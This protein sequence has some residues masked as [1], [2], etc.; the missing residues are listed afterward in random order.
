MSGGKAGGKQA[1]Q[2]TGNQPDE[3]SVATSRDT[4][5]AE[6]EVHSSGHT[7]RKSMCLKE[8]S[9][10]KQAGGKGETVQG[11]QPAEQ[12]K[13]TRT[14]R[15]ATQ[16]QPL[17]LAADA[18]FAAALEAIP[19]EDWCRTWAAVRTIML[20]RTSKRVKEVVDKMRL[21]AVVRLSRS[22]WDDARNGTAAEKR[23][24]V[25]RQLPLMTA[26]CRISTLAL[27]RCDM[28]GQDAE[29]L[30][31]VL[32]QCPALAHLDLSGN[33]NFRAA[34]AERLAGVLGQCR[35][36]VHL[37]LSFIKIGSGGAESLAGVLG[38]WPALAHLNLRYNAIG[39][40]GT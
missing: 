34:G 6:N 3:G 4:A 10:A 17:L 13:R 39:Q 5:A 9:A 15:H 27:P 36:L 18:P 26:R 30:A 25:I 8:M 19:A 16:T 21:P 14:T 28:K 11:T 1:A 35:E 22:F 31:G 37:N 7:H 2:Y 40:A 23:H 38:Q 29:I 12:K 32:A 20:R 24:C 33:F